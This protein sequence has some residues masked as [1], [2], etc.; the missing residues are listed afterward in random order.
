MVSNSEAAGRGSRYTRLQELHCMAKNV[1]ALVW[2]SKSSPLPIREAFVLPHT[3]QS[4]LFNLNFLFSIR[5]L[6]F[7]STID[8][9]ALQKIID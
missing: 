8:K 9:A 1:S 4:T 7:A 3:Q 6:L 2:Y 5:G